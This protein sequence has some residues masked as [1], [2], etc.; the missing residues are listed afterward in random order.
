MH[1]HAPPSPPPSHTLQALSV[2]DFALVSNSSVRLQP[3]LTAISGTSGAGKSAL[4]EALSVLL[5]ATPP[6]DCVR[7]PA[8]AAVIEGSWWLGPAESAAVRDLLLQ[9]GLPSKALP[10][11]PAAAAAAAA[12]GGGDVSGGSSGGWLHL[13]REVGTS[14]RGRLL[15]VRT[16]HGWQQQQECMWQTCL[17]AG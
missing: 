13:R 8:A 5:G 16:A 17:H 1:H 7:P 15:C 12:A 3:G 6:G 10:Q 14:A 2:R 11:Q 4:I 9:A